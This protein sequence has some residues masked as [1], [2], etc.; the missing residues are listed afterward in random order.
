MLIKGQ[1]SHWIN[2]NNLTRIK[3]GWQTEYMAISA[4]ESV[5]DKVRKYISN[6]A[7]HYKKKS[8]ADEYDGLMKKYG[9]KY[10]DR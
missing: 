1:S 4:S 3:F 2:Q 8:Y 7:E 9:I 6:Q 10:I 5:V